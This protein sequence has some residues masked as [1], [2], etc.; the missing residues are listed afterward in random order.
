MTLA[1]LHPGQRAIIAEFEAY[2]PPIKLL[3]LGFLP[4]NPVELVQIAPFS[5]PMYFNVNGSHLAIRK[6]I[7]DQI[8]IHPVNENSA[9]E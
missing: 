6:A 1:E 9:N 8:V 3:E 5:D 7:A 4:G 2:M